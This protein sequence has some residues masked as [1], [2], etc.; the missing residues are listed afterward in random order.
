MGNERVLGGWGLVRRAWVH[1]VN[2][3]KDSARGGLTVSRQRVES[4]CWD[5]IDRSVV[6]E[7]GEPWS[8]S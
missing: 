5:E 2:R 1:T 6:G 4:A 3:T 8:F 7:R